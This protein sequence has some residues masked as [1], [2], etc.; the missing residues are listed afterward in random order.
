MKKNSDLAK[1]V[2]PVPLAPKIVEQRDPVELITENAFPT[3][4]EAWK[5][6]KNAFLKTARTSPAAG[7]KKQKHEGDPHF[8]L[9]AQTPS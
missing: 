1:L 6:S 3:P 4:N 7:L 5:G 8:L 9:Q 2:S